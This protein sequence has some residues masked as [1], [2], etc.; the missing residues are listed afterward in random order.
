M[1]NHPNQVYTLTGWADNFTGNDDINTRLR[2][3]R[4]DGVYNYLIKRGVNDSQLEATTD[5][6]NLLEG[7]TIESAPLDRAVTIAE[8]R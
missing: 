2:R 4:V 5:N 1:G 3:Q 6:G 8:K 7:G